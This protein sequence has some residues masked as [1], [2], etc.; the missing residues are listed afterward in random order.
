[1]TTCVRWLSRVPISGSARMSFHKETTGVEL[2]EVGG[3]AVD[4]LSRW[5]QGFRGVQP[6]RR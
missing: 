5:W 3:L 2:E 4:D 6:T 1:M